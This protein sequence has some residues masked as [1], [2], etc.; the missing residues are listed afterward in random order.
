MKPLL[1]L[2][3][4]LMIL[5]SCRWNI[6]HKRIKGNGNLESES[7]DISRA[8]KIK[9]MGDMDVIL[10]SGATAIR[11][12]ADENLLPYI[13]T[14]LD[15][16]WLELKMKRGV[17]LSTSNPMRIY[18]TTPTITHIKVAG[19]GNVSSDRKFW[20][21]QEINFDIAGSGNI[22]IDV[23]TPQVDADI[24]GSGNL[25]ISGETRDVDVSIAGSGNYKG[26]DLKA[27][28]AKINIAGSGD[29]MVFADV[30]MNARIVGSGNIKYK[31]NAS[32]DRKVIGSGSI[33]V[34][35]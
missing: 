18:I 13:I 22:T 34:T 24:A 16:N 10:D 28:N 2:L 29:A 1:A 21:Q 20:S 7:R 4:P 35:D 15:D 6:N 9:L 12:E 14:E 8:T 19:S 31:G 25:N 11:V 32:V 5:S 3:L 27:E 26:L 33:S 23:N 30:K 17:S